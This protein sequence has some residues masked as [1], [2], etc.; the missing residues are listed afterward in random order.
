[1]LLL[2]RANFIKLQDVHFFKIQETYV[3]RTDLHCASVADVLALFDE[4]LLH[5]ANLT[6]KSY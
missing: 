2:S 1:M 5:E 4:T 3:L 6:S